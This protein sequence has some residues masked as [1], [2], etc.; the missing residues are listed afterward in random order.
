MSFLRMFPRWKK[1]GQDRLR[2][3]NLINDDACSCDSKN[4]YVQLRNILAEVIRYLTCFWEMSKLEQDA[5]ATW[6]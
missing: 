4:C 6:A 1:N 5:F 3:E 2:I